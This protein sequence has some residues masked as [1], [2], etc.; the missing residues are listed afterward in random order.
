MFIKINFFILLTALL[1]SLSASVSA[2]EKQ[3][4]CKV[5]SKSK[6]VD[7]TQKAIKGRILSASLIKRPSSHIY[8]VKV[9][10]TNGRVKTILVDGCKA[11]I[12]KVN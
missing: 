6:A 11:R 10:L 3:A 2:A 1:L 4:P 9:L 7:I 12:I 8:K 5:I